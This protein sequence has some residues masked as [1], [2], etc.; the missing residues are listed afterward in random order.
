MRYS[1]RVVLRRI[2]YFRGSLL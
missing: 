2:L 1:V